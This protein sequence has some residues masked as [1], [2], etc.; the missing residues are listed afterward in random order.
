[1]RITPGRCQDTWNKSDVQKWRRCKKQKSQM[2]ELSL[3]ETINLS[4]K[5]KCDKPKQKVKL[6]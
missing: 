6:L 4:D 5:S 3:V 1:M 2:V